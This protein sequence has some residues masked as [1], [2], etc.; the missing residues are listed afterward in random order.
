MKTAGVIG[1]IGP[2]ST[3]E[4]YRLI[5][6]LY[7]QRKKDGSY[8]QIVINSI[9]MKKML[10]LIEAGELAEVTKYLTGEVRR[11]ADAGADF[12]LLASNTPHIVFEGIRKG[13]PL[14][15]VSI[16]EETCKKAD[17]LGLKKVGLFGTKF[18]M[19]GRFYE[20]VFSKR[21][22][23]IIVPAPGDQDYIH[24]KYMAELVN[25]IILD[26][27]KSG[28]LEIVN[29]LKEK[30]GIQ[31]LILGGT[32]L[33][34]ILGQTDDRDIPFLDTTRIHVESVVDRLL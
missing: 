12:A 9:D 23:L 28:L 4:Y 22:I 20:E 13:S 1:G 30:N 16:V 11:L 17:S 24:E 2:E 3:V 21:N 19:Q 31:G 8:P 14:P 25:G 6:S 10:D 18:T 27:T 32:E 33:P 34:L 5:I 26:K 15:L 7:R 29:S